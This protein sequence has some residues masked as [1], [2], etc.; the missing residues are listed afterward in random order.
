MTNQTVTRPDMVEALHRNV[1]LSRKESAGLLEATLN[2]ITDS[3]SRGEPFKIK[4][5]ASFLLRRKNERPGRNPKTGQGATIPPRTVV[6]F[7]ASRTLKHL[8]NQ[9]EN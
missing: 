2:K 6:A 7:K 1:G 5:F 8:I 3:L 4:G 9:Q